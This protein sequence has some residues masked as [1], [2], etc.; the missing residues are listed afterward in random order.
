MVYV[1]WASTVSNCS[2]WYHTDWFP[3]YI[4]QS[5]SYFGWVC[6]IA[7]NNVKVNHMFGVFHGLGMSLITL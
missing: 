3:G 7:P 4:W 5:L 2:P 6:W 1:A